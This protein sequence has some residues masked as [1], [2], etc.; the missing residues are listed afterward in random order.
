MSAAYET[1][2][3]YASFGTTARARPLTIASA[4]VEKVKQPRLERYLKVL[5]VDNELFGQNI[6]QFIYDTRVTFFSFD[7]ERAVIIDDPALADFERRKFLTCP[8]NYATLQTDTLLPVSKSCIHSNMR[9]NMVI[10][11][12]ST[13]HDISPD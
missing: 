8:H 9:C 1:R 7:E 5:P 3:L 13:Q 4:Y 6:D 2:V 11:R 10:C 12:C